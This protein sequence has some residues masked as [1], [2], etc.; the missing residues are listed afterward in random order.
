MIADT[1]TGYWPSTYGTLLRWHP[2]GQS[3]HAASCSSV[4]VDGLKTSKMKCR[5]DVEM[6]TDQYSHSELWF[7]N[8]LKD[9]EVEMNVCVRILYDQHANAAD[10]ASNEKIINWHVYPV[11]KLRWGGSPHLFQKG[12]QN[13]LPSATVIREIHSINKRHMKRKCLY[14][15]S[16]QHPL[17]SLWPCRHEGK[18]T[19]SRVMH[20]TWVICISTL[21]LTSKPMRWYP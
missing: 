12:P 17:T 9:I 8:F 1:V 19:H 3:P 2:S 5:W 16:N 20:V 7:N 21:C 4:T 14:I 6:I 18:H 10:P 15:I 13:C 11:N